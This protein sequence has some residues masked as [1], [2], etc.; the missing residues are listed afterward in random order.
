MFL[1]THMS[2]HFY[3]FDFLSTMTYFEQ[4]VT[5]GVISVTRIQ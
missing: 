4:L 2:F 1:L 3:L 5:Q